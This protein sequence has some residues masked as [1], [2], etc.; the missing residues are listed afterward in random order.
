MHYLSSRLD[1]NNIIYCRFTILFINLTRDAFQLSP[2]WWVNFELKEEVKNY[3]F[4]SAKSPAHITV[5]ALR[6]ECQIKIYFHV[7]EPSRD[8]WC[9]G[10]NTQTRH[11]EIICLKMKQTKQ[12][13]LFSVW[14]K[15]SKLGVD[16][17]KFVLFTTIFSQL[18]F[19][20]HFKMSCKFI[21]SFIHSA[22]VMLWSFSFLLLAVL[23]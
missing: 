8:G 3:I 6:R 9:D 14:Q 13:S 11:R 18:Y 12:Q 22:H 1:N 21:H 16:Q 10:P 7:G 20:F 17:G 4:C 19:I 5:Y 15:R 2:Y 23:I